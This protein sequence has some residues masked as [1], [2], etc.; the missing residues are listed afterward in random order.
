MEVQET[1]IGS[2]KLLPL[3]LAEQ[4]KLI[5]PIMTKNPF[6]TSNMIIKNHLFRKLI[7][8][9]LSQESFYH[10]KKPVKHFTDLLSSKVNHS[11]V[12]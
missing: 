8:S 2:S 6:P 11:Y 3:P 12:S 7:Q 10:L 4:P 5:K 1:P 9:N